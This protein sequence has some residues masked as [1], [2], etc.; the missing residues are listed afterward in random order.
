M[1]NTFIYSLSCPRTGEIRYVGKANDVAARYKSHLKLAATERTAKSKWVKSLLERGEAPLIEVIDEVPLSDWSFWEQYWI[2]VIDGWGFR[3]L[4]G[5]KGGLGTGR[6]SKELAEKISATL[7]GRENTAAIKPV[8]A[9]SFAGE[10]VR[11]FRSF[12][13]AATFVNGGHANIVRACQLRKRAYGFLWSK[14][15]IAHLEESARQPQSAEA[16]AR[17]A[18]KRRG[19]PVSDG[20]R[21]RQSVARLG[22]SPSNKGCRATIHEIERQRSLSATAKSVMQ[23]NLGGLHIAT[24][25]SIKHAA[26]CTGATRCG[27]LKTIRGESKHA[28]GFLWKEA[29]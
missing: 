26:K 2:Q 7:R 11:S 16:I 1:E 6:H 12:A 28:A 17:G 5:D 4:N 18:A 23:C 20:T 10:Y 13:T 22:K 24:Y 21:L 9:Y 19:R 29:E 25:S 15:I 27:I 8:H 14:E 3:L